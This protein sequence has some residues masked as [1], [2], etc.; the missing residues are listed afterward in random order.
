MNA[1][2][3]DQNPKER[4]RIARCYK[5]FCLPPV[6]GAEA[7]R[8]QIELARDYYRASLTR[9]VARRDEFRR[10]VDEI[11]E[12]VVRPLQEELDRLILRVTGLR[13]EKREAR[14]KARSKSADSA[15]LQAQIRTTEDRIDELRRRLK[16]IRAAR[17]SDGR[18]AEATASTRARASRDGVELRSHFGPHGLGLH[19]RTYLAVDAA[20]KAQENKRTKDG[21]DFVFGCVGHW[22]TIVAGIGTNDKIPVPDMLAKGHPQVRLDPLP[23]DFWQRSRRQRRA[24]LR[25]QVGTQKAPA[26]AAFPLLLDRPLPKDGMVAE[27]RVVRD[28]GKHVGTEAWSVIFVVLEPAPEE[29]LYSSTPVGI[30]IG[31]RLRPRGVRVAAVHVDGHDAELVLSY[32]MA[33]KD[34]FGRDRHGIVGHFQHADGLR[35]LLDAKHNEIR[36]R[37]SAYWAEQ[38]PPDW[39]TQATANMALWR[40][41]RHLAQLVDRWSHE[42][43]DGDET[44][45]AAA[46]AWVEENAHIHDYANGAR[47]RAL[48]QRT[49]TYRKW[50]ARIADLR[51]PIVVE[52]MDLRSL[53]AR[54]EDE[55]ELP[56]PVRR[57]RHQVAPGM[58][59]QAIQNAA[60]HRGVPVIKVQPAN[61]SRVCP[62]CG[63][64]L[65]VDD[66]G[67]LFRAC[68]ACGT[69]WDQDY[70]AARNLVA[71]GEAYLLEL[72]SKE[73][74]HQH[75]RIRVRKP[76]QPSSSEPMPA[77]GWPAK[78]EQRTYASR[79][80][81]A[82]RSLVEPC[83][84]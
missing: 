28:R 30:D 29:H 20:V 73:T 46:A 84:W 57:M 83:R 59:L 80:L 27:I 66:P 69:I 67:D 37:L 63:G 10:Q 13:A 11:G 78:Q 38:P 53:T 39:I 61:T 77:G 16:E 23:P 8:K 76:C 21:S 12:D 55:Q 25:M 60:R 19:F 74:P 1:K 50:A 7:V 22:N 48:A 44:A 56:Q 32:E 51:R 72:S 43:Y 49:D 26:W 4:P 15:E 45:H 42:R 62:G 82:Q 17:K 18:W 36:A 75:Q 9:C 79:W 41:T 52:D 65:V 64:K 24:M 47:R 2:N 54:T 68:A 33:D 34:Q 14:A 31:W 81:A 70:A 35:G 58:L 6:E 5:F 40:S 71:R 3:P